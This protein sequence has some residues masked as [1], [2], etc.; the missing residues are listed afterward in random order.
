[1]AHSENLPSTP[2]DLPLQGH[3]LRFRCFARA[4]SALIPSSYASLSD[5]P[6]GTTQRNSRARA[7]SAGYDFGIIK[8]FQKRPDLHYK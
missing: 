7:N 1:M 6:T 2:R 4:S 5:C 3:V 8:A